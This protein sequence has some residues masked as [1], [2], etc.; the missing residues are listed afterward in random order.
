MKKQILK[1]HYK[2]IFNIQSQAKSIAKDLIKKN[3]NF[4]MNLLFFI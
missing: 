3:A 4:L 2:E 1:E